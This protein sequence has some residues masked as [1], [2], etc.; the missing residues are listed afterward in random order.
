VSDRPTELRPGQVWRLS[1]EAIVI[2]L[3][4]QGTWWVAT[5]FAC[6]DDGTM[7]FC[8]H[9][10]MSEKELLASDAEY[11]GVLCEMQS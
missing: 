6:G 1:A 11:R 9:R 8:D 3:C 7:I 5:G 2:V 4:K 10:L